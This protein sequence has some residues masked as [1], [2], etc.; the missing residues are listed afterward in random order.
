M[1]HFFYDFTSAAEITWKLMVELR[2]M[3]DKR[4]T[5]DFILEV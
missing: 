3:K 5:P 2:G 4:K 1:G